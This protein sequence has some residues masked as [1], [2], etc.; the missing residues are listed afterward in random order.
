MASRLF[1]RSDAYFTAAA[2]KYLISGSCR[3]SRGA[4]PAD[5]ARLYARDWRGCERPGYY[6][7]LE[8]LLEHKSSSFRKTMAFIAAVRSTQAS[9]WGVAGCL[10]RPL[11]GYLQS[12]HSKPFVRGG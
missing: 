6:S 4:C 12:G 7:I 5:S 1:V 10:N 2:S 3:Q 11:R 9:A 8:Y